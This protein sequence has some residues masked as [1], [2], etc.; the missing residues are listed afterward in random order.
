M[1]NVRR[2]S[3]VASFPA[4]LADPKNDNFGLPKIDQLPENSSNNFPAKKYGDFIGL[5]V[6]VKSCVQFFANF[7]V[8][9]LVSKYG[10]SEH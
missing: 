6:G 8:L 7:L 10:F 2:F 9:A 3:P 1:Q 5:A 4:M